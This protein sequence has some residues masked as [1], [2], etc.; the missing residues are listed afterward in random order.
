MKKQQFQPGISM[1]KLQQLFDLNVIIRVRSGD[2]EA[3]WPARFDRIRHPALSSVSSPTCCGDVP[4]YV[5]PN[6]N[7]RRNQG[8]GRVIAVHPQHAAEIQD[9]HIHLRGSLCQTMDQ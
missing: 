5:K 6:V 2:W 8:N 4:I 1:K 9:K 7:W 3:T